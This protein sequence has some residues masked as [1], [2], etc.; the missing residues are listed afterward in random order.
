LHTF[1]RHIL[2][3]SGP[4]LA[5]VVIFSFVVLAHELGHYLVAR[6]CGIPT[7]EFSIGFPGTPVIWRVGTFQGTLF[8]V[9]LLPFGGFVRF[10]DAA[11]DETSEDSDDGL[12]FEN[13]APGKKAAVLVA[14]SSVNLVLGFVLMV[15]GLMGLR[16]IGL[17]DSITTVI[18]ISGIILTCTFS[19]IANGDIKAVAGPVGVAA[20]AGKVLVGLWSMVGFAGIMSLSIGILNLLPIPGCDGFHLVV[21]GIEAV[22]GRAL[23]RRTHAIAGAA[24]FVLLVGLMVVVTF[25]DIL[26]IIR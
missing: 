1:L 8:T 19:T 4:Y 3:T 10:H 9:R 12:A 24:G 5:F 20:A 25:N 7:L 18:H 15:A 23:S 14:G 21:T 17:L 16:G 11:D 6:R 22:R 26:N 13:L 2:I